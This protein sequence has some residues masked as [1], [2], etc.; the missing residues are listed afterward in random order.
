MELTF[1]YGLRIPT[2]PYLVPV[3]LFSSCGI[4]PYQCLR[5]VSMYRILSPCLANIDAPILHS[6][7]LHTGCVFSGIILFNILMVLFLKMDILST[8]KVDAVL[9]P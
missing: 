2:T 8:Q 5:Q 4:K 9:V 3:L 6:G 1:H 7:T